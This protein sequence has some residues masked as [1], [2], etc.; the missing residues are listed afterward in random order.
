MVAGRIFRLDD[1]VWMDTAHSPESEVVHIRAFSPAYFRL[2]E[3][4]RE[5]RPVLRE[6]SAVVVAGRD[7]SIRVDSVGDDSL[8]DRELERLVR[9]FRDLQGAP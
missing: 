7:V 5:L 6:L 1:G 4:L 2:L 3:E 8:S 9:R